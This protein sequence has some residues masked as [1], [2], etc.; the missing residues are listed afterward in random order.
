MKKEQLIPYLP[1]KVNILVE[2]VICEVEGIDLHIENT[3]IAERV[4]YKFED[5][6]LVLR[7]LSDLTKEIEV[8]GERF[9]PLIKLTAFNTEKRYRRLTYEIKNNYFTYHTATKL[10]K[11]NFDI[12]N[13]IEDG[14]AVDINSL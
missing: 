8:D 1:Y 9:I 10:L 14:W 6:K 12:F 3:L 4:N 2:D 7:P 13:G 5:I 11:W